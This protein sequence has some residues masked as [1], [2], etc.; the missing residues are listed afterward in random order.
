MPTHPLIGGSKKGV[1]LASLLVRSLR[2]ILRDDRATVSQK[3]RAS[4][5]LL[6]TDPTCKL[7]KS[8]IPYVSKDLQDLLAGLPETRL[9]E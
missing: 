2:Q 5:L 1:K 8:A 4:E 7:H 9:T 3:L 6:L